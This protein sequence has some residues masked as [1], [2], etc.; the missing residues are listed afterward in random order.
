MYINKDNAVE[1]EKLL[2]DFV[3]HHDNVDIINSPPDH[4]NEIVVQSDNDS[5]GIINLET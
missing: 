2:G 4:E 5:S 3:E 1:L